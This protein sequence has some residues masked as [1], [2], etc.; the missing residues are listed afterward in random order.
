MPYG[1]ENYGGHDHASKV[2]Q[3]NNAPAGAGGVSSDV[4]VL[5]RGR[6]ICCGITTSWIIALLNGVPEATDMVRFQE[7]FQVLRFQG[8]YMKAAQGDAKG[9]LAKVFFAQML[10]AH[11][12]ARC[13][14]L[15]E[16]SDVRFVLDGSM[17]PVPGKTWACYAGLYGHAIGAAESNSMFYLM[18]PNYGLYRYREREA[19][20][21]ALQMVVTNRKLKSIEESLGLAK[22]E[23]RP[24]KPTTGMLFVYE[25]ANG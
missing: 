1:P 7:F 5:L 9:N 4:Q 11:M 19:M 18:D 25:R 24:G 13:R 3:L 22:K 17:F 12:D 2:I 16:A 21:F 14:L 8:A 23:P 10:A 15:S 6:G 20:L